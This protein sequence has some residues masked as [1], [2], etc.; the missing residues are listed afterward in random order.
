MGSGTESSSTICLPPLMPCHIL[1]SKIYRL[2][3]RA[4]PGFMPLPL[5][6][7]LVPSACLKMAGPALFR[8]QKMST[9]FLPQTFRKPPRSQ[10]VPWTFLGYL[11]PLLFGA[12]NELLNPHPFEWKTPPA[13]SAHMRTD[14]CFHNL[15]HR[16]SQIDRFG[17]GDQ[18]RPR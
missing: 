17:P 7:K 8:G 5:P 12:R 13:L 14:V 10:D 2:A 4:S 3:F 11:G 18:C 15:V 16:G 9:S 1:S 6:P